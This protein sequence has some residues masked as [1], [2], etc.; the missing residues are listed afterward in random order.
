[1]YYSVDRADVLH[2]SPTS[3]LT[4]MTNKLVGNRFVA[5]TQKMETVWIELA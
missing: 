1:M 4:L 3:L 5:K 2:A